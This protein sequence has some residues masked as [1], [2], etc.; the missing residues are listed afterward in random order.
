LHVQKAEHIWEAVDED[1]LVCL[2][3]LDALLLQ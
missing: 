1:F 2:V 3:T